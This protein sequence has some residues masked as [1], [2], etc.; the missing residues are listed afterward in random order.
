MSTPTPPLEHLPRRVEDGEVLDF[1]RFNRRLKGANFRGGFFF[2]ESRYRTNHFPGMDRTLLLRNPAL[3]PVPGYREI[4]YPRE[5]MLFVWDQSVGMARGI[6]IEF[7]SLT[8]RRPE[9]PGRSE[10]EVTPR[11]PWA[12]DVMLGGLD[13]SGQVWAHHVPPRL[14]RAGIELMEHW[15]FGAKSADVLV[16]EV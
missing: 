6:V 13:R 3:G 4:V 10:L 11:G 12:S 9:L 15:L 5:S 16:K 1:S 14:L 2:R 8:H 7:A